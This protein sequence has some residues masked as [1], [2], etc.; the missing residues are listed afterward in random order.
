MSERR[1]GGARLQACG[2]IPEGRGDAEANECPKAICEQPQTRIPASLK[3]I[4]RL[5]TRMVLLVQFLHSMLGYMRIDLRGGQVT[6][7]QKQLNNA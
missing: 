3:L 1:A 7:T 6:M 5:P 2:G 4:P